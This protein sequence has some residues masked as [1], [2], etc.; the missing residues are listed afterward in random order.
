MMLAYCNSPYI[1]PG[2]IIPCANILVVAQPVLIF[3]LIDC[4]FYCIVFLKF[5]YH[6]SIVINI[7]K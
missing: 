5:V 4:L 1:F 6:H 7:I 2:V 3:A